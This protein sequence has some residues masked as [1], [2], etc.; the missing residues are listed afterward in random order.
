[1]SPDYRTQRSA[2]DPALAA[3]TASWGNGGVIGGGNRDQGRV[4]HKCDH[5][6]HDN[7]ISGYV[8]EAV[9]KV[10]RGRY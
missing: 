8:K 3:A 9:A 6:G 1:M 10:T 4:V 2:V 5:C 7:D